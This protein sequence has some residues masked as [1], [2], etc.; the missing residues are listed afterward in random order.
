[1]CFEQ[2]PLQYCQTD[3][4]PPSSDAWNS[5]WTRRY[6]YLPLIK[7]VES[8]EIIKL[9]YTF[10]AC[11]NVY[12]ML[13]GTIES[14]LHEDGMWWVSL[15]E[16][17]YTSC[18]STSGGVVIFEC[19]YNPW[20]PGTVST[21]LNA[22]SRSIF[23]FNVFFHWLQPGISV[24][25]LGTKIIMNR[26][27]VVLCKRLG[28]CELNAL[29]RKCSRG[30]RSSTS[31]LVSGWYQSSFMAAFWSASV[32]DSALGRTFILVFEKVNEL[33][34]L[35]FCSVHISISVLVDFWHAHF[36]WLLI[37]Q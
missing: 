17:A 30:H 31:H 25:A 37:P 9:S 33:R 28:K 32:V 35:C 20:A 10:H 3:L 26:F 2:C 11:R 24:C 16:T 34:P 6:I 19:D 18:K 29:D 12:L 36:T 21:L 14:W 15:M 27:P 8:G 5:W 7:V 1:M 23:S 22:T 4:L 13:T